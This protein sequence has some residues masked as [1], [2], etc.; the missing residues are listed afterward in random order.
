M[1]CYIRPYGSI[2]SSVSVSN[3]SRL[4]VVV[5]LAEAAFEV[6][7][8][9]LLHGS[10][11]GS[12]RL[13]IKLAGCLLILEL[14]RPKIDWFIIRLHWEVRWGDRGAPGRGGMMDE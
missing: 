2:T 14:S 12:G 8:S 3:N 11:A 13:T 6:E 1:L 5:G 10:F 4:E 9:K 7:E